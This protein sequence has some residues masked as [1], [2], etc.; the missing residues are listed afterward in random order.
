MDLLR[1]TS[2]FEN[3]EFIPEKYSYE[4]DNVNPPILVENIPAEAKTLV[5]MI[6]DSDS[7]G[8]DSWV[9]WL[10]FDIPVS[11]NSSSLEI[12]E[13]S[14][15][16]T[17]GMN[18]FKQTEYGGPCPPAGTHRYYFRIYALNTKLGLDEGIIK[19]ELERFMK[20]HIVAKG[21]LMG[22]FKKI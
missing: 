21:E 7:A 11:E 20:E 17:L 6:E 22:R 14:V 15:P 8:G 1:I 5:I 16:G 13:S 4:K 2:V 12:K 18:D 9:H 19:D 10:V 3:G